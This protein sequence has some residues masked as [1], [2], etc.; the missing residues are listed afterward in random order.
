MAREHNFHRRFRKSPE[1][2]HRKKTDRLYSKPRIAPA[3]MHAFEKIGVPGAVPFQPD[4]FQLM[5]LEK[6]KAGDVLVTAPTGAGKT[7]IASQAIAQYLR[8]GKQVWYASPLKALSNSLYQDFSKEFGPDLCGIL[9]G[10]RKE[11]PDAAL[12]VGTTEILRNQLYD[13]MHKGADINSDLVILDEA[14]YLS[15]PD[16]GVVWE[17]V[18]IYLPSRVRLLLLSATVSNAEEVCEWLKENRGTQVYVV[19]SEVRPVPLKMLFLFPDGL[20]SPLSEKKGLVSGVKKFVAYHDARGRYRGMRKPKFD[21]ILTC[22]RKLDLLPAIFFLKSRKECDLAVTA[23]V[24]SKRTSKEKDLIKNEVD[25]FIKGYPHLRYHRQMPSLLNSMVA[26]HHAGQLPYWKM[27]VERLMNKGCLDAIFATSTVAAGVNFPARTV[28]L[29]QSDRFDGHDFSDLSA[30]ELHQMIGR[31]GRRGKDN[32]GFSLVIPGQHQD[33]ELIHE[34]AGS[35]PDPLISQIHINFSMTLNLLKSHVMPEVKALLNLSFANFQQRNSGSAVQNRWDEMV[36]ALK[37]MLPDG[38]CDTGDPYEVME[39]I[40]KR[41]DFRRDISRLSR[42][43]DQDQQWTV[44]EPYLRPGRVF[45]HKNKGIFVLFSLYEDHGAKMCLSH[46]LRKQVSSRKGSIRFRRIPLEKIKYLYDLVLDLPE[47]DSSLDDVQRLFDGVDNHDLRAMDLAGLAG[48]EDRDSAQRKVKT[49]PCEKCVNLKVCHS[50]KSRDLAKLLRAF[51]SLASRMEGLGEGLWISFKHHV[52]FLKETGFVD[53]N[54]RLTQDGVWASKLRLDEPLLI[55]EAIRNNGMNGL[56]P[57]LL[58]GCIAPFVWDRD[59]DI[60]LRGGRHDLIPLED[61]MDIMLESM[62]DIRGLKARR[63]FENPQILAWP[64][65]ALYF[66]A[67]NMGW[68][69][70]L[71]R[72]PVNEG[73]MASLIMRTAEHLRQVKNLKETHSDLAAV[74]GGAIALIMREPVLIE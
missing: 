72:I 4:P 37:W 67:G 39:N 7:W 29:L 51:N 23:C 58:A 54:D 24:P 43:V 6:I 12:I 16:R 17:E 57:E 63:G 48:S 66:W 45:H 52:R 32:I 73:D 13:A 68:E 38:I 42:K 44:F 15:D 18:L 20:V 33:A 28:V 26:S 74:A 27:L 65:A 14:H 61:A 59:Q 3:L 21:E 22:L 40:Q 8:N 46:N 64:A 70:L 2:G 71:L 56:T 5:A 31:A 50:K 60:E 35:P 19:R 25:A 69:E 1:R 36:K 9:T 10:D 41:A 62:E 47:R 11:N 30:T 34:L 49:L 55:A 53:V